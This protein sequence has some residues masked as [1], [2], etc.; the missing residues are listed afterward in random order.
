M[1]IHQKFSSTNSS[2][3]FIQN[4]KSYLNERDEFNLSLRKKKLNNLIFNRRKNLLN[5]INSISNNNKKYEIDYSKL[6]LP[7]EIKEKK[8]NEENFATNLI[9]MLTSNNI[10]IIKYSIFLIRQTT[11]KKNFSIQKLFNSNIID[12][13]FEILKNNIL[14][15]NNNNNDIIFEILWI[16]INFTYE[17]QEKSL[18]IYLSNK[19]NVYCK[20]FDKKID[21]I[22][23]LL[24]W[25]FTHLLN[26][27]EVK[28]NFYFSNILIDYILPIT[29]EKKSKKIFILSIQCLVALCEFIVQIDNIIENDAIPEDFLSKYKITKDSIKNNN[30]FLINNITEIFCQFLE[31]KDNIFENINNN[32]KDSTTANNN[33]NN[34]NNSNDNNNNNNNT[35]IDSDSIEQNKLYVIKGLNQ[36]SIC[37]CSIYNQ[38]EDISSTNI[39][40]LNTMFQ[41]IFK[42]GIL[43]KIVRNELPYND[44]ANVLQI[45][46]GFLSNIN[47]EYLDKIFLKELI[48][49]LYNIVKTLYNNNNTIL[50]DTLWALSNVNLKD[51]ELLNYFFNLGIL[52]EIIDI[53]ANKEHWIARE[54]LFILNNYTICEIENGN[55]NSFSRLYG[56]NNNLDNVFNAILIFIEKNNTKDYISYENCYEVLNNMFTFGNIVKVNDINII[57][58]RFENVG[59]KDKLNNLLNK[60]N[61][62]SAELFEKL[63]QFK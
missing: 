29:K 61:E 39:D 11:I 44:I 34:I 18:F 20:I 25:L 46:G 14:N 43:R 56:N 62:N 33:N 49:F 63:I 3:T 31:L 23:Y 21:E 13:L 9:T 42:Y 60:I 6:D 4:T 24:L 55:K 5:Q 35:D 2:S 37:T 12:Y 38:N 51:E 8:F 57:L 15:D 19:M 41:I 17:I 30:I 32:S 10:D 28:S 48:N 27:F 47:D 54:A 22:S 40:N 7:K 16:F 36:L 1:N 45:I 53:I 52:K 26:H 50:R 58:N 59:G